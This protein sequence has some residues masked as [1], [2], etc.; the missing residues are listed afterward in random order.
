MILGLWGPN[1]IVEK[2]GK[3]TERNKIQLKEVGWERFTALR[4]LQIYSI[5]DK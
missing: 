3:V 4:K 2:V 5:L 1:T